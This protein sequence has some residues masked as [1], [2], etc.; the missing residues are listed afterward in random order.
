MTTILEDFEDRVREI[1]AYTNLLEKLTEPDAKIFLPNKKRRADQY[2]SLSEDV[3]ATLKANV[4]LLIY[5]LVEWSLREGILSIYREMESAGCHYSTIKK[6][7]KSIWTKHQYRQSF[8]IN[9]SWETYYQKA[10]NIL[11]HALEN[12]I[13]AMDRRAIPI[14]GN[15]DADQIRLICQMHG[16]KYTI[17]PAARGGER[18]LEVKTQRNNLA[19][20]NLRFAECG[21]QF[22]VPHLVKTKNEAVIFSR[23]ILKS[24]ETYLAEK[25]YLQNA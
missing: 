17:P 5:N 15:L 9:S 19:H 10:V 21:R 2:F 7:I 24:I 23:G 16:I 6:E 18:L 13:I 4:F 22:D 3:T 12:K 8:D 11:D 1:D 25:N 14:S 20:G